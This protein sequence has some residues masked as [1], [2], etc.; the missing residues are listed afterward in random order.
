M[1]E[2][3]SGT[4]LFVM[5]DKILGGGAGHSLFEGAPALRNPEFPVLRTS[6]GPYSAKAMPLTR[7]QR[8]SACPSVYRNLISKNFQTPPFHGSDAEKNGPVQCK[9]STTYGNS[10]RSVSRIFDPHRQLRPT[11]PDD[12]SER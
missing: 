10:R 6:I 8:E 3:L 9:C 1:S 7:H 12:N 2:M 4:G 11:D 5:A